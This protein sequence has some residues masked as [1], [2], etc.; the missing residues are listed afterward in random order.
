VTPLRSIILDALAHGDDSPLTLLFGVRHPDDRL[1]REELESLTR[2]HPNFRLEYSLSQAPDGFPTRRGYVQSHVEELWRDLQ[3]K[4]PSPPH[5]YI[6]GLER[7]VGSVRE[8]LRK[9]MGVDRKQ[10]HSERYD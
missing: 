5:A 1:Y 8:L 2:A 3:A 10:V 7:M 6:C 4:C 9:G